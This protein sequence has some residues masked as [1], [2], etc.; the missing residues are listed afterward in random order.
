[1]FFLAAASKAAGV[2]LYFLSR[3]SW[4]HIANKNLEVSTQNFFILVKFKLF[5]FFFLNLKIFI[6]II[7]YVCDV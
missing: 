1:M 4:I 6:I 3:I 5:H 2:R 7:V